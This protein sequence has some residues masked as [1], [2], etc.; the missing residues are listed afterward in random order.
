MCLKN[1]Q[2]QFR[3]FQCPYISLHT[4]LF[5]CQYALPQITMFI[6]IL[7]LMTNTFGILLIVDIQYYYRYILL[8][9]KHSQPLS[10]LKLSMGVNNKL[11]F[12]LTCYDNFD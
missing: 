5:T 10:K 3:Y 2:T 1:V 4:A 9:Y 11:L 12:I 6:G 7:L 8:V